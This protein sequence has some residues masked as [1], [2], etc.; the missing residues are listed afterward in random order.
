MPENLN[1]VRFFRQP[2]H[3]ALGKKMSAKNPALPITLN[4]M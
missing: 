3:W 1:P 2:S 4:C